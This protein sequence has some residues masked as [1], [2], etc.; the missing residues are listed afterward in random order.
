MRTEFAFGFVEVKCV[1]CESTF[2][3]V[4]NEEGTLCPGCAL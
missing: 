2:I 3:D 4:E 1:R